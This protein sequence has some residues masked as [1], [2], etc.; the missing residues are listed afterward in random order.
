MI[1]L[2]VIYWIT[3]ELEPPGQ[4]RSQRDNL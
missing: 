1:L 3:G 4:F 2:R